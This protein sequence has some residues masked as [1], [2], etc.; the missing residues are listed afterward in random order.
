MSEI[1]GNE[2]VLIPAWKECPKCK[3]EKITV[4]EVGEYS[5]TH[6]HGSLVERNI[7]FAKLGPTITTCDKCGFEEEEDVN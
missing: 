4:E 3:H 2:S 7:L 6:L 1:V 5:E